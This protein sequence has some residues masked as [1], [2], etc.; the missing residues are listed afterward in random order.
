MDY[1]WHVYGMIFLIIVGLGM[2]L[3]WTVIPTEST[4]ENK[5]LLWGIL[6]ANLLFSIAIYLI[7]YSHSETLKENIFHISI[8]LTCLV[9]LPTTLYGLG[10]SS[11]L[12]SN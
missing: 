12:F 1:S 4:E 6:G 10:V 7:V 8:A 11:I 9:A 3:G 5:P 2:S